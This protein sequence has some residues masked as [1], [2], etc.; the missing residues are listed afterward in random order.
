MD[1]RFVQPG[2]GAAVVSLAALVHGSTTVPLQVAVDRYGGQI[3]I[4][5]LLGA[6]GL[7]FV[8]VEDDHLVG[9]VYACT[10]R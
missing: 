10:P 7:C 4:P 2:E 6:V 9:V 5:E 3:P 1:V 8:V